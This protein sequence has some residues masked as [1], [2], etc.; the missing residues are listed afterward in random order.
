MGGADL[1]GETFGYYKVV[2]RYY[3]EGDKYKK[4]SHWLCKCIRCGAEK[5]FSRTCFKKLSGCYN[6]KC[7]KTANITEH[8][9]Y[10]TW[11]N[12]KGRCYNKNN[13]RYKRYGGKGVRVCDE[14]KDDFLEYACY[15]ITLGW[16]KGLQVDRIDND[17]DYEPSNV[18]IV[19]NLQNQFNRGPRDGTSKYKGVS[20]SKGKW[21][22]QIGMNCRT[23][24]IGRYSSEE[25]AAK[26]YNK[27]AKELFGEYAYLNKGV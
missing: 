20:K 25:E 27:K 11:E 1:T 23:I 6:C 10:H 17:G 12:M 2:E 8:S 22:A 24:P 9:L 3:G 18:R 26:A 16:K 7:S 13:P 4:N 5:I 21:I 15:I 19:T 14:W